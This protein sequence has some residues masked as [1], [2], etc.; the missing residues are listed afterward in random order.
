MF[1]L[2]RYDQWLE[3][4]LLIY[5]LY[6]DD[7]AEIVIDDDELVELSV[8]QIIQYLLEA[9]QLLYDEYNNEITD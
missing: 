4:L 5:C 2:A 7:E 8:A 1:E 3:I 6:D 9:I